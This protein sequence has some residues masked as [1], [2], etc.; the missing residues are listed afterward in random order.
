MNNACHGI[1]INRLNK[2]KERSRK[3]EEG[4]IAGDNTVMQKEKENKKLDE[5]TELCNN[6]KIFTIY[7]I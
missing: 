1:L 4:S 3:L 6:V 5:S 2:A 7:V